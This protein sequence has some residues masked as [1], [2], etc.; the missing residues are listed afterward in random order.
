MR[1]N[2]K[3]L[4]MN[5]PRNMLQKAAAFVDRLIVQ[6]AECQQWPRT[7]RDFQDALETYKKTTEAAGSLEALHYPAV[8]ARSSCH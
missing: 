8:L 2:E 5:P 3:C 4:G 7:L 6:M 1:S